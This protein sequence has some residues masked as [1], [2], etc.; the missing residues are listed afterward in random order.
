MA[1][2]TR[3]AWRSWTSLIASPDCS[4]MFVSSL[5]RSTPNWAASSSST[6]TSGP[7]DPGGTGWSRRTTTAVAILVSDAT[8]TGDSGPDCTAYPRE[9]MDTAACPP[10]G[11]GSCGADP[12]TTSDACRT[13]A[14]AGCRNGRVA[15][16]TPI[17]AAMAATTSTRAAIPAISHRRRRRRRRLC[18]RS[19]GP[20]TSSTAEAPGGTSSGGTMSGG[21]VAAVPDRSGRFD[22]CSEVDVTPVRSSHGARCAYSSVPIV[23]TPDR[24]CGGRGP[25]GVARWPSMLNEPG[26]AGV[27][28]GHRLTGTCRP[29]RR[30]GGPISGGG[31]R[32]ARRSRRCRSPARRSAGRAA[33]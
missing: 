13:V 19:A 32:G 23:A 10:G 21:A 18:G 27:S 33:R 8:G 31:S 2:A 24:M 14:M 15:R 25:V 16:W 3:S 30:P 20:T 1:E 29:R 22:G 17:D 12:G 6:G 4:G 9:G 11:Q 5:A 28:S 7:L 26:L